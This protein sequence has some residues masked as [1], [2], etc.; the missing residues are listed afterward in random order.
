MLTEAGCRARQQ[1]LRE[2]LVRRN[3]DAAAITDPHEIYYFTGLLLPLQPWT[4]PGFFWLD[5]QG[6]SFLAAPGENRE[7]YVA[8]RLDYDP[9]E[10]ATANPDNVRRLGA[11]VEQRLKG[12]RTARIAY[13][14]EALPKSVADVIAGAASP[15]AWLA[16]DGD[17]VEMEKRKDP[18][19][20]ECIRRSVQ[21]DLAGYRAAQAAIAPGV[22]E[23][24]VLAAGQRAAELYAGQPVYH[25]GDYASGEIGGFARNR[26]IER[27][28]LYI[29]DAQT[30]VAG[31]WSDLSRAYIVGDEPTPLQQSIFDHIAA[32]HQH[33]PALLKPGIDG[34]EVW[35]ETD[36]LI[37][38]HPALAEA[39]LIHH[40]GHNIGLRAHEQPDLNRDR[41][42]LLEIGNVVTFE[43]GGYPKAAR[44]GVRLE[45]M[46]LITEMGAQNLSEYPMALK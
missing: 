22:N 27:G 19:E 32:I 31:Y 25:G 11:L 14:S 1:R 45:N 41:G 10:G 15:D 6:Q 16:I 17:L 35:R 42:G 37:R 30:C 8:E 18:D 2:L 44:R 3:A 5:T 23:L 29:V 21:A 24:E 36:R 9:K 4:W 20:I 38:E 28:E 46:Y 12:S 43:P 39:G 13:Q 26:Q 34:R 40:A 33:V 7:G